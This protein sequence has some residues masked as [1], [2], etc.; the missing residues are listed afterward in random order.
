MGGKGCLKDLLK[1]ASEAKVLIASGY[2]GDATTS[3]HD[4]MDAKG[5]VGKPFQIGEL[6]REV[7]RT[8]DQR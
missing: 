1:I 7:R 5:F 3:E 4:G 8:L 6:L 2:A